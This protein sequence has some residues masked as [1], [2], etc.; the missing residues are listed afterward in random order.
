MSQ[1]T[2]I[3]KNYQ[4][5]YTLGSGTFSTVKSGIHQETF[6]EVA[7]KIAKKNAKL[8][9]VLTEINIGKKLKYFPHKNICGFIESFNY[10]GNICIV[11]EKVEGVSLLSILDSRVGLCESAI[12]KIFSQ[13]VETIHHIHSLGIVHLD[14]K[15][16][17]ILINHSCD[18]KLIDFGLGAIEKPNQ[19]LH[20]FVGTVEYCAPEIISGLLYDGKKADYWSLGVLLY[21]CFV[22][23]FPWSGRNSQDKIKQILRAEF[24]ISPKI[25]PHALDLICKLVNLNPNERLTPNQILKHPWLLQHQANE[26]KNL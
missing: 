7:I 9:N 17:N 19:L 24:V 20:S 5:L 4:I 26:L 1:G 2:Q 3:L 14:I 22:G 12:A 6:E 11:F 8:E 25:P 15:P 23:S 13:V 21:V 16:E 18:I 10:D